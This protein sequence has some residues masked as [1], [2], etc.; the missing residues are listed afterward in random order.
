MF[1]RCVHIKKKVQTHLK[2]TVTHF[3][4]YSFIQHVLDSATVQGTLV[5]RPSSDSFKVKSGRGRA[6]NE[7]MYKDAA[8]VLWSCG[9]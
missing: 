3:R 8:G 1:S 9:A 5:S 4:I 2:T 7:A 6:G